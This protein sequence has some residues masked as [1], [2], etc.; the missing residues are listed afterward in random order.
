MRTLLPTR[1]F[2]TG[3]ACVIGVVACTS[4]IAVAVLIVLTLGMLHVTA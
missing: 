4:V 3:L 1:V 2:F